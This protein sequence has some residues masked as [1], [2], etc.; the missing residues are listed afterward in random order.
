M[1]AK[2]ALDLEAK[3]LRISYN[4]LR[5]LLGQELDHMKSAFLLPSIASKRAMSLWKGPPIPSTI[6]VCISLEWTPEDGYL[7]WQQSLEIPSFHTMLPE[8]M[9][10]RTI[11]AMLITTNQILHL[12]VK[13]PSCSICI[14]KDMSKQSIAHIY[15]E[16]ISTFL[17]W[18]WVWFCNNNNNNNKKT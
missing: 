7:G 16:F 13:A 2:L 11:T 1:A 5:N 12:I 4:D 10:S 9:S 17:A 6:N 15:I 8:P 18:Q 3:G 14:L